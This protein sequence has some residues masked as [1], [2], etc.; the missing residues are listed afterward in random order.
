[1]FNLNVNKKMN[2][3]EFDLLDGYDSDSEDQVID[4][5]EVEQEDGTETS[6]QQEENNLLLDLLKERGIV[7]PEEIKFQ[8]E[9]GIIRNRSWNDLSYEEQKNI[10]NQASD[11]DPEVELDDEEIEF[12]NE[13]RNLGMTPSQYKES[14]KIKEEVPVETQEHFYAVDDLTDDELFILDLQAKSEEITDEEA[15]EALEISKQNENLHN[16][17]MAGLR[18]EYKKLE[19]EK[20]QQIQMQQQAEQEA[21][22]Q[23]F[24]SNISHSIDGLNSIGTLD[25]NLE[26]EDKEELADF[27]LGQDDSGISYFGKA[28]NDPETLVQMAWFALHGEDTFNEINSYMSDQIKRVAQQYY[29]KGLEEGKNSKSKLV[30]NKQQPRVNNNKSFDDLEDLDFN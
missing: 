24:R 17:R 3:D 22:L 12:I 18:N 11:Y 9:D 28:L 19:D 27:I 10:L 25:I 4:Q 5:P 26:P 8:G 14:L 7:N 1:M 29:N 2:D 23:E 20:N 21:E 16:K 30:I 15:V 6:E 13:M